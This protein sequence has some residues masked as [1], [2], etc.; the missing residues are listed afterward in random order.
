[1][2]RHR[3]RHPGVRVAGAVAVGELVVWVVTA[4]VPSVGVVIAVGFWLVCAGWVAAGLTVTL[5]SPRTRRVTGWLL[6]WLRVRALPAGRVWR[7]RA[8]TAGGVLWVWL[9]PGWAA[10]ARRPGPSSGSHARAL[11]APG[12]GRALRRV[13]CR[14]NAVVRSLRRGPKVGG[15][16][17]VPV[18]TMS[19]AAGR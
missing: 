8:A 6:G 11:N 2:L 12:R 7:D 1:M 15:P 4:V 9:R 13:C 16:V 10:A 17:S 18:L 14:R 19:T 3:R 5:R